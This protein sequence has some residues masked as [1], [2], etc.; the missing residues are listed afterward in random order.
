VPPVLISVVSPIF[1][2]L[3]GVNRQPRI[4]PHNVSGSVG[5]LDELYAAGHAAELMNACKV[6]IL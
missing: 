6:T 4:V 3:A 2:M 1:E 5:Q